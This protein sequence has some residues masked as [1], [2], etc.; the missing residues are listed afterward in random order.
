MNLLRIWLS[1]LKS[2]CVGFGGGSALIPIVRKELVAER[3]WMSDDEYLK[4]TLIANITPGTLPV[5]LGATCGCRLS[6]GA[7]S[8]LGAYGVFLPG[9]IAT[10]LVLAS[11]PLLGQGAIKRLTQ[12][13]IGIGVFIIFLLLDYVR[14]TV[15][16]SRIRANTVICLLAFAVTGEGRIRE[17]IELLAGL[18]PKAL[19]SSVF[20]VSIL[21]TIL[22]AFYLIF[23]RQLLGRLRFPEMAVGALYLLA[24]GE[25]VRG[26]PAA[27]AV[28]VLASI[29][30]LSSL[31]ICW[32]LRKGTVARSVSLEMQNAIK[33]SIFFHVASPVLLMLVGIISGIFPPILECFSL[34]GDVFISSITSFGGGEG[35]VAVADGIFVQSGRVPAETFYNW[36]IPVANALPGPI[37]VKISAAIGFVWGQERASPVFGVF[38]AALCSMVASGACC[39]L[40]LII[41]NYYEAIKDSPLI[42]SLKRHILAVIC[43]TLLSTCLSMLCESARAG[44]GYGVSP[45]PVL[46]FM[47]MGVCATF[48]LRFRLHLTDMPLLAAW[49]GLG[50]AFFALFSRP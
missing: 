28:R 14:E 25:A 35:Y 9:T 13:G 23:H 43:G 21:P 7:T 29:Y 44:G 26:W 11:F 12:A 1:F 46:S 40:A 16:L 47:I 31:F 39:S 3:Q 8:L 45:M 33:K 48:W 38:V 30:F 4:H 19:G 22:L 32:R 17:M 2:G 41:M 18:P 34:M 49:M 6:G 37:L 27:S 10:I 42:L 5:K 50:L 24:C 15:L 36:I 20:N